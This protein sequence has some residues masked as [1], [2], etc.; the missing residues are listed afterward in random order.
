[1]YPLAVPFA[2]LSMLVVLLDIPPMI[3]HY[4][5][6]N[7]PF[8]SL[9][10][11]ILILN[12]FNFLNAVIWPSAASVDT[13]ANPHIYQ[14]Q[15][16]CDVEVKIMTGSLVG[17]PCAFVAIM[18]SL[19]RVLDTTQINLAPT[20]AQKLR[21]LAIDLSI[22]WIAPILLMVFHFIVQS[23]RYYLWSLSG[24]N[25]SVDNSLPT[26]LLIYIWP[27][28]FALLDAY[29][30]ILLLI[31]IYR[32]RKDFNSILAASATT[33]SRFLRPL[34]LSL[35]LIFVEVPLSFW[36]LA[37]NLTYGLHPF[38]YQT[39]HDPKTWNT[40]AFVDFGGQVVYDRWIRLILGFLVF[41]FF[42]LGQDAVTMY[43]SWLMKAGFG[44]CFPMLSKRSAA[45]RSASSHASSTWSAK[46]KSWFA[47]RQ[48]KKGSGG[49]NVLPLT[50]TTDNKDARSSISTAG[51]TAVTT[52]HTPTTVTTVV[53][54]ENPPRLSI[55][56]SCLEPMSS[57]SKHSFTEFMKHTRSKG[58]Q[59]KDLMAKGKQEAR[60]GGE[61]KWEKPYDGHS[62]KK[63]RSITSTAC[64]SPLSEESNPSPGV[65]KMRDGDVYVS[66][67]LWFE[68]ETL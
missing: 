46:T 39:L 16:L 23:N 48:R 18:R 9:V 6:R 36:I 1:M 43:K 2:I 55:S 30:A 35:L 58:G 57:S 41:V 37:D 11:W 53:V 28:I 21:A 33:R 62:H 15:G 7:W 31:R 56:E 49:S 34:I 4:K 67:K 12:I 61:D 5:K 22:T 26:I 14:G 63:Q 68:K 54:A 3:W 45:R 44:K 25:P 19:A 65:E 64:G 38:N 59:V 20:R 50:T 8:F 17:L 66:R 47:E 29:Y 13:E 32:Y 40:I 24:C 52:T 27:V 51:A 60:A 42:G 10:F